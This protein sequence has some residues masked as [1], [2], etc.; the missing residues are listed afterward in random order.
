[1]HINHTPGD[2]EALVEKEKAR[3]HQEYS[4]IFDQVERDPAREMVVI[5]AALEQNPDNEELRARFA[6]LEIIEK[7][8]KETV[9]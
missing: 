2:K 5:E 8:K 6:A 4:H 7:A 9:E 3:G 1:M